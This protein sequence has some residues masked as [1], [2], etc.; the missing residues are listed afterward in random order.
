M[1]ITQCENDNDF[2]AIRLELVTPEFHSTRDSI[3]CG[4][5]QRHTHPVSS[6]TMW[7]DSIFPTAQGGSVC[8]MEDVK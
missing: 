1:V 4:V 6:A 3:L 7:W 5:F 2:I 8:D